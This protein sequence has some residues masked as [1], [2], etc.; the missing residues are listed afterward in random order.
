MLNVTKQKT[1]HG[2]YFTFDNGEYEFI[3][4][5]GGNLDLYWSIDNKDFISLQ[6]DVPAKSFNIT[7]ENYY[8]YALFEKLY[9]D[10]K[11]CN[12]YTLGYFDFWN[13]E[14]IADIQNII[15]DH[16]SSNNNLK[17]YEGYK[18][19][20]QDNIINWHSD[21]FPYDSA[22]FVTIEKQDESFIVTFHKSKKED[23]RFLT[24][25]IRFRNSGSRYKPFNMAF[26][27]MYQEL[28]NYEPD[29]HQI[30][31]EEYLYQKK[32]E[33]ELTK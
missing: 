2:H 11:N 19:L 22:S 12:I 30:H 16:E 15:K 14:T 1:E 4:F 26:M 29:Y 23:F 18:D 27:K 33:K 6:D 24:Y 28:I 31:I 25:A 13:A 32:L 5:F 3:I 7:K 21:E 9:E 20:F 10:I 17:K 8:I